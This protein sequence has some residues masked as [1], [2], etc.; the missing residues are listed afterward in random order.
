MKLRMLC[1]VALLVM[2]LSLSLA[3]A[4][5]HEGRAVGDYNIVFGWRVEPAYTGQVNG[6]EIFVT[7][8]SHEAEDEHGHDDHGDEAEA[9]SDH[10]HEQ[11]SSAVTGLEDTLQI[12]VMFGPASRVLNLRAVW[13]SPGHY[14]ADLLPTMPGDYTFR[15]FGTID[16]MEIDEVFSAADGQFSSVEPVEDIQFP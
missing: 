11:E 8:H 4:L 6:P 12:E 16:G 2:G 13:N 3:P 5:A 7:R 14:T 15:V 10:G 1:L 9:E